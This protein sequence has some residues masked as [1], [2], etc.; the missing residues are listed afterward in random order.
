MTETTGNGKHPM[1]LL[2]LAVEAA[3]A[4]ATV[5]EISDALE[6]VWGRHVLKDGVVQGAYKQEYGDTGSAADEMAVVT[7]AV[8][9]FTADMGRRPRILVAKMGQDGHDRG[10]KVIA[11][12]FA[13]MG[14]DVDVGPLFQTPEEVAQQAIDADVHAVGISS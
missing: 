2:G 14:F 12:G 13:D 10:A 9:S 4:R 7:K 5:G 8:D 6:V 1:N 3:R 11:S